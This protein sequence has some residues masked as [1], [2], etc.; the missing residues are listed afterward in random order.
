M[1]ARIAHRTQGRSRFETPYRFS[2]A[3]INAIKYQMEQLEKVSFCY[4]HGI[5]G[6][7]VVEYC[8][9]ALP[10][11]CRK[12]LDMDVRTLET[13]VPEDVNFFPQE[14]EEIFTLLRN[15][16]QMRL[17]MKYLVPSPVR[18]VLTFGRAGIFLRRAWKACREQKKLNVE[19][20]DAVAIGT[21]LASGDTATASSIMFL[22]S[23]GEKLES[24]TWKKSKEDFARSLT[25]HVDRVFVVEEDGTRKLCSLEEV[26][27]GELVE[28]TM[29]NV[30][31]VDGEV[32]EGMG[33]VNEASFTG[34]SLPVQKTKGKGVF[35][36]TALE[37]GK[38]IV[39]V[40]NQ[41]DDSRIS[42]I[43]EMISQSEKAKSTAQKRAETLADS[44]VKYSFFG[45]LLTYVLTGSFSKAKAFLMVDF[46]CALKLT[47]PIATM[48]A[49]RQS[50]EEEVLVKGGKYLEELAQAKTI[51]FDKTGTLTQAQPIV[52]DIITFEGNRRED[53]L[54]IAACLEEHFPHSIAS[55][56]VAKAKE[57]GLRHEEMH[58]EPEYLVAHGIASSISGKRA[59]IG[60]EHFIFEDEQVN[61]PQEKREVVDKLKG[62]Y[63]LLYLAYDKELIAVLC[64]KDPIRPDA[65]ETISTLRNLGFTKIVMLTGD[66]ENSAA[67]VAK[68][69][70]LDGY[71]A[72]VLPEDKAKFIQQEKAMGNKV[73]MIGDGIN[74][75]VALSMADVGISMYRGADIA[76][77]ISDIAIGNDRLESIV[78]VVKISKALTKR[79]DRDYRGIIGFNSALILGGVAGIF[80]NTTSS[81]LHNTSTVLAAWNNMKPYAL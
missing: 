26:R 43:I 42:K 30:I 24:W 9:E 3:E 44:L 57:E 73:V 51:V 76:R 16:F 33:M 5:T 6:S 78:E 18:T 74:D 46:S 31:P 70:D 61:F 2:T 7:I 54:R 25:L 59:L 23:L 69:L 66:H 22:L 11:I 36:G 60:S 10:Q 52:E 75:S 55:A 15:S 37:E 63:S 32:V 34:E 81:F 28:I 39:R 41:Y 58:S 29:G 71:R 12:I 48:R 13:F 49:M 47:V 8:E 1:R 53:C 38:I 17:V 50:S 56:V 77:E 20:L 65:K 68:E 62:Q 80:T 40:T 4:V 27:R 21:S 35:A 14:E 67:H 64:I 72:Q 79:I 45:S 19:L